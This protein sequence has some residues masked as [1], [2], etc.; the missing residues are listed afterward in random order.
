MA[1]TA[2]CWTTFA[3]LLSDDAA[4]SSQRAGQAAYQVLTLMAPYLEP[5]ARV[6]L[7]YLRGKYLKRP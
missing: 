4:A 2:T 3:E 7:T 6:Y 1:F 5:N